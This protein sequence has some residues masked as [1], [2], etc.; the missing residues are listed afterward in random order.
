MV[1]EESTRVLNA[2]TVNDLSL[3]DN[4]FSCADRAGKVRIPRYHYANSVH[5]LRG[6]W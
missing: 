5:H 1:R 6:C 4:T 3:H 2:N